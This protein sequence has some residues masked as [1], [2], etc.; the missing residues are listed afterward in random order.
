MKKCGL[1]LLCLLAV[2]HLAFSQTV[3][4]T[5][6]VISAEDNEPVIGASVV[7]K[8]T[9]TGTVT[10]VDGRFSLEIPST[11]KTLV[12]SFV[13]M[14]T[15]EAKATAGVKVLLKSDAQALDEV[16]VV[17]YGTAKKSSFTGSAEVIKN[18]KIEARTVANVSKALDGTV[19]GLQTTSGGGQPGDGA[20]LVIRGFGSINANN[21][22]L[23]VLDGVP[24]DGDI[25]AINPADIE[26]MSVLKDASASALYGARGANGVVIITT[27][28]G[29][30]GAMNINLKATWGVSSRAFPVYER[31]NSAEYMELAYEALKN[32]Y[33]Y[34]SGM[35][36]ADAI[37][38]TQAS[39]MK[40]LGGE[41][42]NPFNIHSSQLIDPS[43][44]KIA[45]NAQLKYEDD[46]FDEATRECPV[47]QE[48]QFSANGGNDRTTYMF[49]LGYLNEK[50]LAINTGFKRYSGRVGVESKLKSWLKGALS[51]Q[52]STT[53]QQYMQT[54]GSGY[55][56][57][58][59]SSTMVAPIYPVY[60]R[61]ENGNYLNGEKTFDY[62]DTRAAMS[63]MNWIA[64]LLE[65]KR[66]RKSDNLTS[67]A[68]FELGDKNNEALGF[69]KDFKLTVNLGAD[70]RNMNRLVYQN[71]NEG[72]AAT[73]NGSSA[74][75]AERMLSFTFNQL[76]NYNR[77][78]GKHNLDVLA[79]HE[80]YSYENLQLY[81]ARQNFPFSGIYELANASTITDGTSYK[82]T[83]KIE[84]WL[85]RLSY[86]FDDRYYLSA[87]FRTDGS[88]RFY[89]DSRWGQ[90]WSVGGA[91]RLSQEAFMKPAEN[92]LNNLTLKVSYGVQGN[93]N[94]LDSD[95]YSDYYPWQGLYDMT[96]PNGNLSGAFLMSLENRK[97]KW[98][99][100]KNLNVGVEASMFNSRLSVSA[101]FY[102]KNTSD[103]LLLRP[104]P[105]S[106]G[107]SGYYDNIGDMRN[108]GLDLT[109][110]GDI[111]RNDR[112]TWNSSLILSTFKN[113]I[114]R[115][116]DNG[117][118]QI[119][120]GSFIQK[121]GEPINSF[122]MP[123]A[124]GVDP[125]T[126]LVQ[127]YVTHTDENG[128]QTQELTTSYEDATANGRQICGS[129]IPDFTGSF[130]NSF[131]YKNI[132][133][134][135]LT[136]FSV[137]G[138]VYDTTYASLMNARNMGYSWS[139]DMLN[140]WQQ[141]GDVTDVPRI[142]AGRNGQYDDRF[143]LD[144]SYFTL[145]NISL[146]YNLPKR[147]LKA[148]GMQG[149]RIFATGDNLLLVS[150]KKGMDPQYNFQGTQDY[151]YAPI[152]TISFGVDIK[153]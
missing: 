63:N 48:Y 151:R 65:D 7:A 8:G 142:Q 137:G 129:R 44:G 15:Q 138:K 70:Y 11:V 118:D 76:L 148:A 28:R 68:Y 128:V 99:K 14:Q 25:S 122:Y 45:A 38:Q 82:D 130:S 104:L 109:V 86:N 96:Y 101:E 16:M 75:T 72:N 81:A 150:S 24:Y 92:W 126:G 3:K 19:A 29:K 134:S 143:L 62:G 41:Q 132:D 9:T 95:G 84:S 90:F 51:A 73:V 140:R 20:K 107:F 5:G 40:E 67:R 153:F 125:E 119:I 39:F 146:G 120:S 22:P 121:V 135:V 110:S 13:G 43:T 113:K 59:Y 144:A 115:L 106:S 123:K 78:F 53:N 66:E 133:L 88:S 77:S 117:S 64:A 17:A 36:E 114:T 147:W 30:S 93:D 46:W 10:D 42:Y 57:I 116:S 91:W 31:V 69:L 97:L 33:I 89:T 37:Q 4:I 49:S 124:E 2:V 100:N 26:S 52:F 87:S 58:W 71:P 149:V 21:D 23:Y 131:R 83:Y 47:R 136:T 12:V 34:A 139:K 55:Y 111:F 18:D 50:G 54:G 80:F 56:N 103:L 35:S 102:V 60:Q 141:P 74:R 85:S 1:L 108:T 145:K 79:G 105:S 127:Y 6:V 94:L 152:R 98:E 32:S 61:D 112:F 27:K